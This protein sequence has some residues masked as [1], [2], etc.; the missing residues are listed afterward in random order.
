MELI[1]CRL[2]TVHLR[3]IRKE[4]EDEDTNKKR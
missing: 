2:K 1:G 3:Q 4:M